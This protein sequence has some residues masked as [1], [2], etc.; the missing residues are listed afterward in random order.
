MME[1]VRTF[2]LRRATMTKDDPVVARVREARR[3]IVERCGGDTHR[4]LEWAKRIEATR[5]D[6]VVAYEPPARKA[7]D[8]SA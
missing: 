7:D 3:R 4:L 5:R 8:D 2:G 6:R 1:Q